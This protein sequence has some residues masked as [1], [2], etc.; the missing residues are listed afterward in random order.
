MLVSRTGM[1]SYNS[2][3]PPQRSGKPAF[4]VTLTEVR[5]IVTNPKNNSPILIEGLH[6]DIFPRKKLEKPTQKELD[7][8]AKDYKDNKVVGAAT[9]LV[10]RILERIKPVKP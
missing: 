2:Y 9:A 6:C 10:E 7:A 3:N 5:K 8:L 4:G 1:I